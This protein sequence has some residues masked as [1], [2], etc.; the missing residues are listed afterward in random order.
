MHLAWDDLQTVE[1]LVRLGS[2]VG[3]ARELGLR[4]SSVSR[5]IDALERTL[6]SPL[7]LRGARLRPTPLAL[8]VAQRAGGMRDDAV[9]IAAILEGDRRA[10]EGRLV[11]TTSDVLAPLLFGAIARASLGETRIEVVVSDQVR[12]LEPGITD[13]ALRPG[14]TPDPTLRGR[15]V[16]ELRI[17]VFRA[18]ARPRLDDAWILPSAEL[19]ARASMRWWAAIPRDA[20]SRTSCDSLLAIRDACVAGL[21]RAVLP[22]FLAE[23]DRR[24]ER[25]DEVVGGTPVWLLAPA[26]RRSTGEARRVR[27]VLMTELRAAE[28]VWR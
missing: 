14:H 21:G 15:K 18:R 26:T 28:G 8:A 4:H 22:A 17:G 6:G 12:P 1:A 11:V 10:A 25:V 24:L 19:R 2:V 16:G 27:S 7:F 5:R 20:E 13:L 23:G 9:A 3:A